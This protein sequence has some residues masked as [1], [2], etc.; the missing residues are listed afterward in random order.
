MLP[1]SFLTE[2][3]SWYCGSTAAGFRRFLAGA[4]LSPDGSVR[5]RARLMRRMALDGRRESRS[6][7]EMV[8]GMDRMYAGDK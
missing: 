1:S 7:A 4:L 3:L 2:G 8:V 5:F 6:G